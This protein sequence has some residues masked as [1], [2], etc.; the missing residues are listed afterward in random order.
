M[1]IDE[2]EHNRILPSSKSMISKREESSM[3]I[4]INNETNTSAQ[5][6]P[7]KSGKKVNYIMRASQ[8]KEE[9]NRRHKNAYL[10]K[11][12]KILEEAKSYRNI[13]AKSLSPSYFASKKKIELKSKHSNKMKSHSKTNN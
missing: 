13:V 3:S 1:K 6:L 11:I 5:I 7:I 9:L 2:I 4:I 10:H 12:N 8:I